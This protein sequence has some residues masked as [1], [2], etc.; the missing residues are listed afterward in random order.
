MIDG[1]SKPDLELLVSNYPDMGKMWC[2]EN[3]NKTEGQ[4]RYMASKLGLKQNKNS[5]FFDS[6]QKQAKISKIGKKRP[7][8][9]KNMKDLMSSGRLCNIKDVESNEEKSK[10]MKDWHKSNPHPKGMLGKSHS[11]EVKNAMSERVK[12]MW[13]DP[14]SKVNSDDHRQL[15]S[16]R[17]S[18]MQSE[19][20]MRNR[21]SRSRIGTYNINGVDYFF[22]SLWEVN[23]AGTRQRKN[24]PRAPVA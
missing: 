2:C 23:Y 19:G 11:K 17:A 22:R 14:N 13:M 5:D 21:Y 15:L 10:R 12:A 3:I 24:Q 9:A 1:W 20:V 18:K 4:I 8:H 16:D 6:W 7:R